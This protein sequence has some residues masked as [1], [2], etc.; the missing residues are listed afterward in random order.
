MDLG[1]KDSRIQV[2]PLW[3]VQSRVLERIMYLF[4]DLVPELQGDPEPIAIEKARYAYERLKKPILVD[5][6]SLCFNA[7]KGLPGPYIKWFLK[8]LGTAGL[9]KMVDPFEDKTASAICI[10]AYMSAE[11]DTP[12]L[13]VG[14][15]EGR[16]VSPRG[17][18]EFGWFSI[19][20]PKGHE[21]TLS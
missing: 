21:K 1:W 18:D 11:L 19:F 16:I 5:D 12:K 3:Q 9:V 17:S 15:V 2:N 14:K 8:N 7:Y 10:L 4:D 13:F 6:G 20:E